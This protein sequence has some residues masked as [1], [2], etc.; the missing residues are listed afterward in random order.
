[1]NLGDKLDTLD[2]ILFLLKKKGLSDSKFQELA[3]LGNGT[4]RDW[5]A[6]KTKSYNKHIPK[7]AEVLSVTEDYLLNGD[8]GEG[9]KN[10][11]SP[12]VGLA[13]DIALI[14]LEKG[15]IEEDTQMEPSEKEALLDYLESSAE[16]YKKLRKK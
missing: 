14:L 3:G 8:A 5:R 7:I 11:P 2:R 15:I 13:H 4:V 10:E 12:M 1:M 9:I 6:G 16:T